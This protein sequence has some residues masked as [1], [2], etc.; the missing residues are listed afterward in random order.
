MQTNSIK[1]LKERGYPQNLWF[2]VFG[3]TAVPENL[4][5]IVEE[6]LPCLLE[7]E[8]VVVKSHYQDF[9]SKK[10]TADLVGLKEGTMP[11]KMARIHRKLWIAYD[12]RE[13]GAER[14]EFDRLLRSGQMVVCALFGC[15]NRIMKGEKAFK[16]NDAILC[17][18]KCAREYKE[19]WIKHLKEEKRGWEER[20]KEADAKIHSW[21]NTEASKITFGEDAQTDKDA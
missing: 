18:E 14:E 2:D 3:S 15:H 11:S 5:K 19:F 16:I 12:E 8:R 10:E 21:E 13:H 4:E 20:A 9:Q 1:K 17:S 6:L 7:D